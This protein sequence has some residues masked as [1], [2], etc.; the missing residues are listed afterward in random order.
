MVV[1]SPNEVLGLPSEAV[2]LKS[3]KFGSDW[4]SGSLKIQI[5][6]GVS[7]EGKFLRLAESE[8]NRRIL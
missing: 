2:K 8:N 3:F 5:G 4:N 7:W 6:C 1:E